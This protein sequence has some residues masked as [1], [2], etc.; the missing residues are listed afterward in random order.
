[1]HMKKLV[2]GLVLAG[3]AML[4]TPS[5]ADS[6][7]WSLGAEALYWK[8]FTCGWEYGVQGSIQD[9]KRLFALHS[10]YTWGFRLGGEY[11]TCDGF[12]SLDLEWTYLKASDS[13]HA[14][15]LTE[16]VI[17]P[18]VSGKAGLRH[19]YNR[20]NLRGSRELFNCCC[21][22]FYAY[23]GIRY[24]DIDLQRR[25]RGFEDIEFLVLAHEGKENSSYWGVGIEGGV[26]AS[27]DI[28]CGFSLIGR[29]GLSGLV[30]RRRHD[31]QGSATFFNVA[32]LS[33]N[34]PTQSQVVP[35]V[36]MQLGVSYTYECSCWALTGEIGYENQALFDALLLYQ[37]LVDFGFPNRTDIVCSDVS[38][39][40]PYIALR[41]SF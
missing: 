22:T 1:M 11:T 31:F 26:G 23:T 14:F 6:N 38:Y 7:C 37:G 41:V 21:G 9:N 5:A 34:T 4:S 16:F 17:A 24:V 28:A 19:R 18:A 25:F 12:G 36:D 35:G 3:A 40:G 13:A 15:D 39:G 8:P 32:R 10:D 29:F 2:I 20:V 33:R 27:I 30:G